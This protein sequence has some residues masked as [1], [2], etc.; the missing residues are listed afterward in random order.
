[1]ALR[2]AWFLTPPW[3]SLSR[4][5]WLLK[6]IQS[7]RML[8]SLLFRVLIFSIDKVAWW[9]LSTKTCSQLT[10]LLMRISLSCSQPRVDTRHLIQ[11][12]GASTP[13][14]WPNKCTNPKRI[15]IFGSPMPTPALITNFLILI[16]LQLESPCRWTSSKV[17]QLNT[18]ETSPE[19]L[20]ALGYP[21]TRLN[22]I[23]NLRG[24]FH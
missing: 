5:I 19:L 1:M 20:S 3:H 8:S 17:M 18:R 13:G 9:R 23:P 12:R 11:F 24:K 6:K 22:F 14:Q 4:R 16:F 2:L 10:S 21:R 15:V 7:I